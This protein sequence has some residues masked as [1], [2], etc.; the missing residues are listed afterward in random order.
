[1]NEYVRQVLT[2]NPQKEYIIAFNAIQKNFNNDTAKAY[3]DAYNKLTLHE[4]IENG[5]DIVREPIYGIPFLNHL[6]NTAIIPTSLLFSLQNKVND[7]KVKNSSKFSERQLIRLN[8]LSSS[9]SKKLDTVGKIIFDW[10]SLSIAKLVTDYIYEA[11]N[12]HDYAYLREVFDIISNIADNSIF[13]NISILVFLKYPKEM[14]GII[15]KR[16]NTFKPYN[17]NLS[18]DEIKNDILICEFAHRLVD[19]FNNNLIKACGNPSFGSRILELSKINPDVF[20]IHINDNVTSTHESVDPVNAEDAFVRL[21]TES[22]DN[23][24]THD[25]ISLEKYKKLEQRMGVLEALVES[26][27]IF[28]EKACT[29]E[30]LEY[31]I[32]EMAET[33]AQMV[34]LEYEQ[35]GSP[36]DVIKTHITTKQERKRGEEGSTPADKRDVPDIS[37]DNKDMRAKV[38]DAIDD[39]LEK[40]NCRAHYVSSDV[41]KF[42]DGASN[43]L[44]LGSFKKDDFDK[45]SKALKTVCMSYDGFKIHEDNYNTITLDVM[46]NSEYYV[47][48]ETMEMYAPIYVPEASIYYE[49]EDSDKNDTDD[50]DKSSDKIEK[51]KE[52]IY[53]KMQND[54]IDRDVKRRERAA[55]RK[56]KLDKLRNT[57]K[58]NTTGGR[59]TLQ[60]G[61]KFTEKIDKWDENTRKKYMLKPG[62]RHR[63]FRNLRNALVFGSVA[64]IN[65]FLTPYLFIFKHF[66][67]LKNDRIRNELIRELDTEIHIAEEKIN[68]ANANGDQKEKYALMRIKDKLAAERDRVSVNSKYI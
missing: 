9:I 17:P 44:A 37:S 52:D 15:F 56:E 60:S 47:S 28:P 68:D 8:I 26:A 48:E 42:L 25:D 58:L 4:I 22:P 11:E 13:F 41:R 36:N 34:Y 64:K 20:M 12:Q 10:K 53:T 27:E 50:K 45:V 63:I 6:V 5:L 51:P 29:E 31:Y 65:I 23:V 40:L 7:Y 67:D 39:K 32:Q 43:S 3:F 18:Q 35:D 46:S 57:V 14:A 16:L 38:K 59:N 30:Q 66:S 49:E 19:I 1:M 24:F 2:G 21:L 33:E 55:K 61:L 54:A 62:F